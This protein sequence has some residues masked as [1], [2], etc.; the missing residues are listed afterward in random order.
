MST[1]TLRRWHDPF[2]ELDAW[3]GT[4]RSAGRSVLGFRPAA[5]VVRDGEDAVVRL[6]LPGLDPDSDIAVEIERGALV[7]KGERR[8]ERSEDT[9]LRHVREVRY[10]AFRRTFRLPS[11]ITEADLSARYDAGILTVRVAGAYA[12]STATR[13]PVTAGAPAEVEAQADAA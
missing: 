11:H 10:G 13:I 9:E 6:E 12:G 5:E 7:V 2:A 4:G 1:L 3:L 8:D